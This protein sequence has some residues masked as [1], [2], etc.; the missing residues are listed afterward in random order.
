MCILF[1]THGGALHDRENNSIVTAPVLMWV[2]ALDMLLD[3]LIMC[4]T[5]FSQI[6]AISGTAQVITSIISHTVH[7][8]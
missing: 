4:G 5:D 8:D 3:R 2:K 6:V 7:N 1:R